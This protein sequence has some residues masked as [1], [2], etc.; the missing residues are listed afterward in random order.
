MKYLAPLITLGLLSCATYQKTF[1]YSGTRT[2]VFPSGVYH[3]QVSLKQKDQPERTFSGVVQIK[4]EQITV[5]GLSTFGNTLFKIMEERATQ[6]VKT[7]VFVEAFKRYEDKVTD[8]YRVL[9][10]LLLLKMESEAPG[11]FAIQMNGKEVQLF[12]KE[13]DENR[14]PKLLEVKHP[15]FDLSVK[16]VGY[17]VQ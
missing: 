12:L 1:N 10:E 14:I 4:E 16:V 5:V 6:K 11:S 13:Y 2:Q 15:F 3:H 7:E 17:N 9:R 8:F